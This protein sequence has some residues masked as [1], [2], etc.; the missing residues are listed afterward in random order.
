MALIFW[1][2]Y[3][4]SINNVSKVQSEIDILLA[5]NIVPGC[6]LGYGCESVCVCVSL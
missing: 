5:V 4:R 2:Q 3:H 6:L 1:E